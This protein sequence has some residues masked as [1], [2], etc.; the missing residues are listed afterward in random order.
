MPTRSYYFPSD[1]KHLEEV[2][3]AEPEGL[4]DYVRDHFRLRGLPPIPSEGSLPRLLGI[5]P[6]TIY[7]I[8]LNTRKHYRS[9]NIR[10]RDGSLREIQTPRTYLKV[11]QWW[12]LDNL[13]GR[14]AL[15]E[16]VFGF[17]PGR[18]A[19]QNAKFHSGAKH[20]LNVDIEQFFPSI[21]HEQVA[22][23]F[24][25]LGYIE[26][27]TTMLADLCCVGGR[28]PQGAPTSPAIANL[29][30]EPLDRKLML[31][32]QKHFCR[33]SRYADDLSFS[34][35]H[36]IEEG[37]VEEVKLEVQEAG[38][39][40]KD[41]KTRFSGQG[42]RLEVTGVVINKVLQPPLTWRKRTRA[43]LHRMSLKSRLT[44]AELNYLFGI[45][46]MSAQYADSR[47]M[48][49]LGASALALIQG[50][51]GTV[52]GFGKN[53]AIPN[54]LTLRQALAVA[55]LAPRRTNAEIA[56]ILGG[57][58]SAVKTRLHEAYKKLGLQDRA[59][60]EKWAKVNL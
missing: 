49:K 53:P 25:K 39:R 29:V 5:S 27:V 30:L 14:V 7:S 51:M 38:F 2:L 56:E 34:S 13:L 52:I 12:L 54:G 43:K 19:V 4:S 48:E 23:I 45:R 21:T 58:E 59:A 50:K 22:S 44:R 36:R 40:L 28:V 46:G 8:R 42:G 11:I 1:F 35:E 31:I 60:A 18:S 20:I 9:F 17:V 55:A 57:T 15:P 37:L 33:Y 32:G 47:Q 6:K 26:L 16:Y 10:K 3:R 41:A 24:R